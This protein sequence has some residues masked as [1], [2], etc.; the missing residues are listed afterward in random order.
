MPEGTRRK[1]V[2]WKEG[3]LRIAHEADVPIMMMGLDYSTKTMHLGKMYR[4]TG[5]RKADMHEVMRYL[6]QFKGKC[7]EN[8]PERVE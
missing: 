5:D 6:T 2:K 3:F 8:Q 4:A 1:V 7:P